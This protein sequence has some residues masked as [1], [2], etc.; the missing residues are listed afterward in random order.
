MALKNPVVFGKKNIGDKT[1]RPKTQLVVRKFL[2]GI[3]NYSHSQ[4]P[5]KLFFVNEGVAVIMSHLSQ[6]YDGE[7]IMQQLAKYISCTYKY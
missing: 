6:W 3:L 4:Y 1:K 2:A 7:G 5:E